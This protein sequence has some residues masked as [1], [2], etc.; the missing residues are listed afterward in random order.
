MINRPGIVDNKPITRFGIRYLVCQYAAK[1]EKTSPSLKSK[2][3]TPH[4]LRHNP[5]SLIMPSRPVRAV[6]YLA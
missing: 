1:A 4:S 3:V 5:E 6:E 2:N